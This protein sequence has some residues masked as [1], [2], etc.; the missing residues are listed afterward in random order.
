V[1]SFEIPSVFRTVGL[2]Y[3]GY[4]D[5]LHMISVDDLGIAWTQINLTF[6]RER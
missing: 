2:K 1:A 4:L 3:K 5:T 6:S